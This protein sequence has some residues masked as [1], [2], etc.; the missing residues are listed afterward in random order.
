[1]TNLPPAM[2]FTIPVQLVIAVLAVSLLYVLGI[3]YA[4]YHCL[5]RENLEIQW[6]A[7]YLLLIWLV[8][9]GWL[10]YLLLGTGRVRSL[11][12]EADSI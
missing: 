8:P 5:I 10:I 1:M 4:T 11:F 7:V 12:S 6:K 2:S 9:L 3:L